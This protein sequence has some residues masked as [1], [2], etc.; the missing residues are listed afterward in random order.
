M[1]SV[2]PANVFLLPAWRHEYHPLRAIHYF[3]KPAL[4]ASQAPGSANGWGRVS[5]Q[6]NYAEWDHGLGIETFIGSSGRRVFPSDMKA[7]P[8]TGAWLAA[9][10]EQGVSLQ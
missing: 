8:P 5:A 1:P 2:G 7:A 9:L 6:I 3:I 10:R 4:S